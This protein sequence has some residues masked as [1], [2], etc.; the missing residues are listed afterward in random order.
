MKKYLTILTLI[1]LTTL[2]VGCAGLNTQQE[3]SPVVSLTSFKMLPHERIAPQFEIG[4]NIMNPG[5]QALGLKG[6]YYT[7]DIEGY[8]VLAG[9]TNTLPVESHTVKPILY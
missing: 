1:M 8:R 5:R 3:Y 4:L 9:V 2:F 6:I 7:V